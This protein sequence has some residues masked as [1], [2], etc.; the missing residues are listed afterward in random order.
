MVVRWW[1]GPRWWSHLRMSCDI[2]HLVMPHMSTQPCLQMILTEHE[3]CHTYE[4]V[5][6]HT[7][8][9]RWCRRAAHTNGSW[10]MSNMSHVASYVHQVLR[11]SESCHTLQRSHTDR[12]DGTRET[13]IIGAALAMRAMC[14]MCKWYVSFAKEPCKR[15]YILQKR[16]IISRSLLI[17]ATP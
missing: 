12:H 13:A 8:T 3:S 5:I 4:W 6:S 11:I 10:Y 14:A 17:V 9:Q 2:Y 1:M 16:P 7:P 15:D